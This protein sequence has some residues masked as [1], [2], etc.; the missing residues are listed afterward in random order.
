MLQTSLTCISIDYL[1][2]HVRLSTSILMMNF[3]YTSHDH[4]MERIRNNYADK[5]KKSAE[6]SIRN[7]LMQDI[8][9]AGIR[10][11]TDTEF[12]II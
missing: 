4:G 3:P 10:T 9:D 6:C 1:S 2:G 7:T 5:K 11:T 8:Y 12:N